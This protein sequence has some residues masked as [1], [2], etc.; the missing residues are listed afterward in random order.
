M[1]DGHS[2]RL[3]SKDWFLALG[4]EASRLFFA[5]NLIAGGAATW[6]VGHVGPTYKFDSSLSHSTLQFGQG[7]CAGVEVFEFEG[8]EGLA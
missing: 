4:L 8:G 6:T 1:A 2:K 5:E 7:F 3:P